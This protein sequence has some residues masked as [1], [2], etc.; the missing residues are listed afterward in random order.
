MSQLVGHM[1]AISFT[2][3]VGPVPFLADFL[4]SEWSH[5]ISWS[6]QE[7]TETLSKEKS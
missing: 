1:T 7:G 6:D 3:D 2:R 5:Y 4:V